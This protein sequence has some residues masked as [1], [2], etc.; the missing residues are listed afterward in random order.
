MF[1]KITLRGSYLQ[2]KVFV[3]Q[4]R[5]LLPS[6]GFPNTSIGL[7]FRGHSGAVFQNVSKKR[8]NKSKIFN[9]KP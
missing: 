9:C 1:C 4:L 7:I 2:C 5:G 6:I 8:L 3:T